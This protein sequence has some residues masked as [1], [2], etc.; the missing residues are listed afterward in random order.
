MLTKKK[1][2]RDKVADEVNEMLLTIEGDTSAKSQEWMNVL[3]SIL[4]YEDA[5][6]AKQRSVQE[7]VLSQTDEHRKVAAESARDVTRASAIL[8]ER[9]HALN[10][11]EGKDP[12]AARNIHGMYWF[13]SRG[14]QV[15]STKYE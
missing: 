11:V 4:D 13:T 10:V 2:Y 9:L 14:K 3:Q 1:T 12:M 15:F 5:K 8:S 7:W 6:L